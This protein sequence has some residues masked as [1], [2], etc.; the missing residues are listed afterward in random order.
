MSLTYSIHRKAY[1]ELDEAIEWYTN[2][3]GKKLASRF[4]NAYQKTRDRIL[5]N[6]LQFEKIYQDCRRAVFNK[7]PF[8]IIYYPA[9][10]GIH[11]LAIFHASKNPED[12]KSR[13]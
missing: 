9:E 1:A 13:T 8:V 5:E 7:F 2:K 4:F 3:G 12:W 11:I 6:P 10:T